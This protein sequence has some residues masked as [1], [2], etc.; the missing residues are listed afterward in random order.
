MGSLL[1]FIPIPTPDKPQSQGQATQEPTPTWYE[2]RRTIIGG[3]V[4]MCLR[5]FT[6]VNT[7]CFFGQDLLADA[8]VAG[9]DSLGAT[10]MIAQVISALVAIGVIDC[11]GRRVWLLLSCV[12]MGV[13]AIGIAVGAKM[14]NGGLL[15]GSMMLYV[16]AFALG[17]GPVPRLLF[18]E[19]GLPRAL[20]VNVASVA[21]SINWAASWF[22][23]G[24]PL[25]FMNKH[26]G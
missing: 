3:F 25:T 21:T 10:V 19:L 6:G 1:A 24:P 18:P 11:M 15:M 23:T 17:L 12:L 16:V 14:Q 26:F 5:N 9:A 20:A 4:P 2:H 7:I 8:G 13:A 22:V